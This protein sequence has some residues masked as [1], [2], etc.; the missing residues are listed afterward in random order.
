MTSGRLVRGQRRRAA[1]ARPRR[2][3]DGTRART[4]CCARAGRRTHRRAAG[5]LEVPGARCPSCRAR[6]SRPRSRAADAASAISAAAHRSAGARSRRSGRG[7]HPA[8]ASPRSAPIS[9]ERLVDPVGVLP[10]ERVGAEADHAV[11]R[12]PACELRVARGL[13]LIEHRDEIG[14]VVRE[15]AEEQP[16]DGVAELGEQ[17]GPGG[18]AVDD[19]RAGAVGSASSARAERG[20]HRRRMCVDGRGLG[21]ADRPDRLVGDDERAGGGAV[22]SVGAAG[23]RCAA[24]ASAAVSRS[25]LADAQHRA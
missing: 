8:P 17:P 25:V 12:S 10:E 11:A 20:R 23:R 21:G 5:T 15:S 19:E 3:T 14:G 2:A 16:V 24:A 6:S 22:E 9:D 1:S 13:C 18:P 7:R 4:A